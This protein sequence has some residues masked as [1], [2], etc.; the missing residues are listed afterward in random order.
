M[1]NIN[2]TPDSFK[3]NYFALTACI[4]SDKEQTSEWGL[5]KMGVYKRLAD[6]KYKHLKKACDLDLEDMKKLYADG[7]TMTQIGQIYGCTSNTICVFFKEHGVKARNKGGN[8]HKKAP[9]N[10]ELATQM[11]NVGNKGIHEIAKFFHVS[12]VRLSEELKEYGTKIE[13]RKVQI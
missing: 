9:I 12:N 13:R 3:L 5:K 8:N 2:L 10:L 4:L 11:Y 6:V 1:E 7:K